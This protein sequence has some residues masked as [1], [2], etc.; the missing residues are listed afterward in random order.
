[1]GGQAAAAIHARVAAKGATTE[2][3]F[4]MFITEKDLSV[5]GDAY[6]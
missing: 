1:M 5:H 3:H 4:D 6:G 2:R